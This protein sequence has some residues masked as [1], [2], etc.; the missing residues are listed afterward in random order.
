MYSQSGD[1]AARRILP[2]IADPRRWTVYDEHCYIRT[3]IGNRSEKD[4][5]WLAPNTKYEDLFKTILETGLHVP[6]LTEVES[7]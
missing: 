4:A 3:F 7:S 5:M 6:T 1:S 2:E